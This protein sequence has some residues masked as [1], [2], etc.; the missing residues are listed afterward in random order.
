MKEWE[1]I[2]DD[3]ELINHNV[4]LKKSKRFKDDVRRAKK[5]NHRSRV[6]SGRG[7]D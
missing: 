2:E 7:T 6:Q 1:W 5:S 3:I 4:K